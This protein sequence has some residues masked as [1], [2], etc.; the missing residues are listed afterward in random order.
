MSVWRQTGIKPKELEDM[1]EFPKE[2]LQV[3]K[4]FIDLHN[5]RDG[6]GFGAN[7][8]SYS[9]MYSYFKLIDIQPDDWEIETVRKLDMIALD[10]FAEQAKR[11]QKKNKN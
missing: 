1:L 9:D 8:I 5:A 10:S 6:N 4:F 11:E 2:M 3:W 7:P